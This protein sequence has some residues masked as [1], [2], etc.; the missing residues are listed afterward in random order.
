MNHLGE[1]TPRHICV[2]IFQKD[3]EYFWVTVLQRIAYRSLNFQNNK[4]KIMHFF[5]TC[6]FF[7]WIFWEIIFSN[8]IVIHKNHNLRTNYS[9]FIVNLILTIEERKLI[10]H[11]CRCLSK[12]FRLKQIFNNRFGKNI[13]TWNTFFRCL[14][15]LLQVWKHTIP[16]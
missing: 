13:C 11:A 14:E 10:E 15:N 3:F 2:D 16:L 9:L 4:R 5:S 7:A 1:D 12:Y 6:V 8:L